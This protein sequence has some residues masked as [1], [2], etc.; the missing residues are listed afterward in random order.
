MYRILIVDDEEIEREGMAQFIPWNE[1]G[2]ELVGTAK[3]GAEG[4]EKIQILEPDIVL[5]DIK[6]PVMDG[7]ELIRRGRE[8]FPNVEWIVLSGYGEYEF[9]SRAMEQGIRYYLLKPCDEEQIGEVLAKVKQGME[10]KKSRMRKTA[11]MFDSA[12][13]QMFR[14]FL[15]ENETTLPFFLQEYEK[16]DKN[17]CLLSFYSGQGFD[18]IVQFVIKNMLAELMGDSTYILSASVRD[19]YVFLMGE[20]VVSRAREAAERIIR[21]CNRMEGQKILAMLSEQR[22]LKEIPAMYKQIQWLFQVRGTVGDVPVLQYGMFQE[23]QDNVQGMVDYGRICAAKDYVSLAFEVCLAFMKFSLN[24][25]TLEEECDAAEWILQA[26]YGEKLHLESRKVTKSSL[27][28]KLVRSLAEKQDI[29]S[30]LSPDEEKTQEIL[31]AVFVHIADSQLSLSYLAKEVLYRNEDYL[32]RIFQK[33][34]GERFSVFLP[35]IRML[36]AE[37]IFQYRPE[38]KIGTVAEMVGYAPDGQYFSKAFRKILHMTPTQYKE[39]VIQEQDR[40][41][42]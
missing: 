10:T 6:M 42:K 8:L 19:Q 9:T 29:L 21:E 2:V 5:T 34:Q 12:K 4:L 35:R 31:L 11:R 39:H 16:Y 37:R 27:M 25:Y 22:K 40:H 41:R 32:G 14:D 36:L 1:F 17:W 38:I 33:I 28:E 18:G 20:G 23:R 3:N 24:G 26:L 13:E 30:E 7:I 15:L